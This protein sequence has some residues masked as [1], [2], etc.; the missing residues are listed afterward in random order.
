[1]RSSTQSESHY[2]LLPLP[3]LG[4][5][6]LPL[7]FLIDAGGWVA[8]LCSPP[9]R[10]CLPGSPLSHH[11]QNVHSN[12]QAGL[13]PCQPS[14]MGREQGPGLKE[15]IETYVKYCMQRACLHH[16]WALSI[17]LSCFNTN[18][19]GT[20]VVGSLYWWTL[21]D[22]FAFSVLPWTRSEQPPEE[23]MYMQACSNREQR[24]QP[25][26]VS[27]TMFHS[28]SVLNVLLHLGHFFAVFQ[29]P[30]EALCY[31]Q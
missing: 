7:K 3:H 28:L 16:F 27:R 2:V 25:G 30:M 22:E 8:G 4:L 1:M 14:S 24:D 10:F 6:L 29:L 21:R 20:S 19:V 26:D 9:C 17:H 23:G 18:L 31:I 13:A 12:T 11:G 15:V 5:V